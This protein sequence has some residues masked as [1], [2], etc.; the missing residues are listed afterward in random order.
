MR[1]DLIVHVIWIAG[2]RMI[3]QGSDGLSRGDNLSGVMA[4]K[5][6]LKYIPLN[7]TAFE[8]SSLAQT[9]IMRQ[10]LDDSWK[11]ATPIDWFHLVF[12]NP[13]GE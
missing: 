6:F 5:N 11:L 4:G 13:K 10:W 2:K 9:T 3:V 12:Q 7:E 1:G 8:R